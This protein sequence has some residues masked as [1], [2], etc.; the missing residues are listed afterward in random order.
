MKKFYFKIGANDNYPIITIEAETKKEAVS[1]FIDE[2]WGYWGMLDRDELFTFSCKQ[3][4]ICDGCEYKDSLLCPSC[5]RV[6]IK[7]SENAECDDCRIQ[8]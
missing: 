6:M 3:A 2:Y 8:L 4:G 1:K 5:G 7:D